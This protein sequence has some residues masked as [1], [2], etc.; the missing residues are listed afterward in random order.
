VLGAF[1]ECSGRHWVFP[2]G[3]ARCRKFFAWKRSWL[4]KFNKD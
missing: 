2:G 1:G 4:L 3:P